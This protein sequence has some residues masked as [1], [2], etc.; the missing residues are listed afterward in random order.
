VA[1]EPLLTHLAALGTY[2]TLLSNG[3]DRGVPPLTVPVSPPLE[4]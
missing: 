1:P 4:R 2:N 3:N